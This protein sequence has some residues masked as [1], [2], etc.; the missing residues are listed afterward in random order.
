[1][2][3][4]SGEKTAKEGFFSRIW[5]A[6]RASFEKRR[7]GIEAP[8][9][10]IAII[11]ISFLFSRCHII[12]GA[13]PLGLGLVAVL[14][15]RAWLAAIGAA[16][17]S[18]TL[19]RAGIV[20][21]VIAVIVVFLRVIISGAENKTGTAEES[22][23]FSEGILLRMA[24]AVIGGFIAAA[25]EILLN[26]FSLTSVAFGASMIIL[27]PLV[28]FALSGIFEL[29]ISPS[30]VFQGTGELFSVKRAT[31]AEKY[32]V[33]FFQGSALFALFLLSL[34]LKE[35]E[36]L[37]ISAGYI[38]SSLTTIFVARRFG[39]L[40][41]AAVGFATS[42]GLS[43]TFSAAFTLV[44]IGVGAFHSLGL[45]LSVVIGGVLLSLWAGYTEGVVG[46]LSLFPEYA[47]S[48][49][50][51]IPLFKKIKLERTEEEL[52]TAESLAEDM[53]G[54]MALSYKSR[55]TGSLDTLGSSFSSIENVARAARD[56]DRRL[57]REECQ[58]IV[59]ECINE[60]FDTSPHIPN[61]EDARAA[62]MRCVDSLTTIIYSNKAVSPGEF[63]TPA[64][65]SRIS[66]AISEAINSAVSTLLEEKFEAASS[67]TAPEDFGLLSSLLGAARSADNRERTKNDNLTNLAR[68]ALSE[69]GISGFCV[70][71]FGE[72]RPHLILALED[73]AGTLITAPNVIPKIEAALGF[74]LDKP[75][76][77][78]RG[79]MALMEVNAAPKYKIATATLALSGTDEPSGDTAESFDT[80]EMRHFS[81]I[82]DGMGSG[83][84]AMSAS[85]YVS[86]LL[87]FAL[88]FGDGIIPSLS[89][90]NNL[91]KRRQGECSSSLDLFS[92]D[93]INGEAAFY[94]C[95][96]APSYIKRQSSLYRIRSRTQPLGLSLTLDAEKVRA[97][98]SDGDYII[99]FSD[100]ISEDGEE[101]WL[102]ELISKASDATPEALAEAI[103]KGAK[104]NTDAKD[105][106]TVLVG[107]IEAL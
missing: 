29:G 44:G 96:A 98:I 83:E 72:R 73:E 8:L 91:L 24:S 30:I 100:G 18:L 74:K 25:Y 99:M 69:L 45:L 48:A 39:A 57:A 36:L 97:Q 58:R 75:E 2:Q 23:L 94:K 80:A 26:G 28:T 65:L 10:D 40:R 85:H 20:Y 35:Y 53:V 79:K 38:F 59:T 22:T 86:E 71:V 17:G 42:V 89:L 63:N 82:A 105:D 107:R 67:D 95:G 11:F 32:A 21:S 76:Y 55:Y 3:T 7:D 81:L 5:S 52:E 13:H 37:G 9:Y 93:L 92:L 41:G 14:P 88:E 66:L 12:F 102:V 68:E 19:G 50:I 62:F 78:R 106:L 103:L 87:L 34:S 27:P 60:Y 56:R 31:N 46:F 51:S 49:A 64:H 70:T 90:V 84:I 16:I 104:K 101:P 61:V 54:T 47:I 1:M 77:Y 33:I 4:N 15:S 43:G 6:I